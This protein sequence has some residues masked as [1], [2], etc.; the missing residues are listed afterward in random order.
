MCEE[1]AEAQEAGGICLDHPGQRKDADDNPIPKDNDE[2]GEEESEEHVPVNAVLG[3]MVL[4]VE[5]RRHK[6]AANA[7]DEEVEGALHLH[8]QHGRKRATPRKE[9]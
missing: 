9:R 8:P 2:R 6:E 7:Q 4:V 1:D 3:D 5:A